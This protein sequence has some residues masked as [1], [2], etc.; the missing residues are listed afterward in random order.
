MRW[1]GHVARSVDVR[2]AYDIL[3]GKPEWKK[4]VLRTRRRWQDNIR[5]D[6]WEI[7]WAVVGWMHLA[8]DRYQWRALVNTVM[9]LRVP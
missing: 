2:F 6:L 5:I 4:P 8:Q 1:A 3:V 9:S 7:G